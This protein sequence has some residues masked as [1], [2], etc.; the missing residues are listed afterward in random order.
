M[1]LS[2]PTKASVQDPQPCGHV[3][4]YGIAD[5]IP[6]PA[7]TRLRLG[8]SVRELSDAITRR[9][10]GHWDPITISRDRYILAGQAQWM[11]TQQRTE[12]R[13][14]C[15]QLDVS[16]SD[17]LL[18]LIERH[19]RSSSLNDFSR[20]LLAL[21]LEPLF[22]ERAASNRSRGGREKGSSN[23]TEADHVDVRLEVAK[24]AGVSVGNVS[25][26]KK[27]ILACCPE[28]LEA[29]REGEVSI[30]RASQWI[31]RGQKPEDLLRLHRSCRGLR[32]DIRELIARH[33][34]S[35]AP[36]GE[37]L[38]VERIAKAIADMSPEQKKLVAIGELAHPGYALLVSSALLIALEK[39]EELD[40][41]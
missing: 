7:I 5:L 11:L 20:I 22:R 27:L 3:V 4:S 30:H 38:D 8:P 41:V 40:A 25:K 2:S 24:A 10:Q 16:E 36:L 26:V 18:W 6:H 15:L 9:E 23:L 32:R 37:R 19:K 1:T 14:D 31:D 13:I 17:A 28:L 12:S 35:S 21:E 33:Q 34:S 39:Q 29:L